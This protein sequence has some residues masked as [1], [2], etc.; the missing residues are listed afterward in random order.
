MNFVNS[1]QKAISWLPQ[2]HVPV[3]SKKRIIYS[4]VTG[5]FI[6]TL[7]KLGLHSK[8]AAYTKTVI[9]TQ[10]PSGAWGLYENGYVFDTGAV[11]EG[12]L[13]Y[14]NQ[15]EEQINKAIAWI[16]SQYHDGKF[17]N[18]PGYD[19]GV[20]EQ[21]NLRTIA[22]LSDII[23]IRSFQQFIDKDHHTLPRNP[24]F[25]AYAYE[26]AIKLGLPTE[27]YY[28]IAAKYDGKI[29][30]NKGYCFTA[31]SQTAMC[32]ARDNHLEQA[33]QVLEFV[34]Q[35]QAA[36]GGFCGSND[37]YF[38]DEEV[39]WAVKFYLDAF[40]AIQESWFKQNIHIFPED[41]EGG[42][43]DERFQYITNRTRGKTLEVGCGKGRYI[44]RLSGDRC[45]CDIADASQ[46]LIVPFQIGS[47]TYLPYSDNSFDTVFC[48]E[49]LEHAVLQDEAV[50]EMLRVV[51]PGGQL[52]I[53]DKDIKDQANN[54]VHFGEH[55]V[56]F[57]KITKQYNGV[58]TRLPNRNTELQFSALQIRK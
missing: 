45:A 11:I 57:D 3:S 29:P 39:S 13:Q 4:E 47:C 31:L 43:Q 48:C 12:L 27:Q 22:I 46:Y 44:N 26:G 54:H 9:E 14:G 37:A 5:Y 50:A 53:I 32:L 36:S 28:N 23:D 52:L 25:W 40:L 1:V 30:Y 56:D 16:Q 49:C 51:R 20:P 10:M 58:L 24:H 38:P 15:Y 55:W 34:T 8:A 6:P 35:F 42:D 41:F 33:L 18:P 17:N 19:K 21:V 7:H 2:T